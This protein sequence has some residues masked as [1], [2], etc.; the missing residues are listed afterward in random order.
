MVGHVALA[1]VKEAVLG[2]TGAKLPIPR[3]GHH[4][5]V[6]AE[7]KRII[8]SPARQPVKPLRPGRMR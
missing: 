4:F 1:K 8:G 2:L 3:E 7:A 5:S 6:I